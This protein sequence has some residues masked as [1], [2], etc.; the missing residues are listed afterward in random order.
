LAD[1]RRVTITAGSV[2]REATL[3]DNPTADAIWAALPIEARAS[4]WG[5]AIY[6]EISVDLESQ[7]SQ[8][9]VQAG[10]LAYWPP[11]K[12][13]A[14]LPTGAA[15][16]AAAASSGASTARR[17]VSPARVQAISGRYLP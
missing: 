6:F 5:D 8:E 11:G 2:R 10:D 15:I 14:N 4:R 7:D 3:G 13:F 9:L 12:A 17:S 16:Y 1:P